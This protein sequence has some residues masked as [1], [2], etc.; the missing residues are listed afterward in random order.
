[1]A[2]V[3]FDRRLNWWCLD[4]HDAFGRRHQVKAART[5]THA[6]AIL[7]KIVDNVEREKIFGSVAVKRIPFKD[8]VQEHLR[9]SQ[10]NKRP[11]HQNPAKEVKLFK[12]NNII[13]RYL[14]EK[15]KHMLLACCSPRIRPIVLYAL[16]TGMRKSKI[17][18][19][20]WTDVDLQSKV[21]AVRN[22]KGGELRYIPINSTLCSV[23]EEAVKVRNLEYPQVFWDTRNFR[24]EW[25]GAV[26]RAGLHD[27]RFHDLRHTAASYMAMA[28][29]DLK[30]IQE[31]LG[32]KEIKMTLRYAHLSPCA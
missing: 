3:Y 15:E 31:I 28:G 26:K 12:Q 11:S 27:F 7:R 19:L 30:T 4:Y 25:E 22:T 14:T 10:A 13:L 32:H 9:Y 29:I 18:N 8:I 2:R 24:K 16:H 21:L 5:K 1:M 20:K 17:L 23:F 6:E